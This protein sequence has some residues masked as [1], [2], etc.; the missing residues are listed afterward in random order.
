MGDEPERDHTEEQE[1]Q[2][3]DLELQDEAADTI[4]GGAFNKASDPLNRK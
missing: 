1:E 4:K 2:E 3:E